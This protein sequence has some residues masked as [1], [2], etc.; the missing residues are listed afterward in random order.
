MMFSAGMIYVHI[1]FIQQS[2]QSEPERTG[3]RLRHVDLIFDWVGT[4]WDNSWN[5]RNFQ[6]KTSKSFLWKFLFVSTVLKIIVAFVL[7]ISGSGQH[8][9]DGRDAQQPQAAPTIV[10]CLANLPGGSSPCK[11]QLDNSAPT[12]PKLD[13]SA[14]WHKGVKNKRNI[15]RFQI[16]KYRGPLE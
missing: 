13:N 3:P 1:I 12:H 9:V 11:S 5:N 7:K 15:W 16:R 6:R 10:H 4:M 8:W 14:I 2:H